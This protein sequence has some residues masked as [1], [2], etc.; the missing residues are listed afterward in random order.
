MKI[1]L[2]ADHAGFELKEK[3]KEYLL[4]KGGIEVIDKGTNSKES[5]DYP[6]YGHAVANAV[7][8]K[9]VDFGI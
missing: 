4:K 6:K 2:G 3:I 7:V 9:E 8:S 1:A 5:V